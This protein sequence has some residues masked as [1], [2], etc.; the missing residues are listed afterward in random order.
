MRS[1]QEDLITTTLFASQHLTL[2]GIGGLHSLP[3]AC[4]EV[5]SCKH[6]AQRISQASHATLHLRLHYKTIYPSLQ[7]PY[8]ALIPGSRAGNLRPLIALICG[9]CSVLHISAHLPLTS[10]LL[11]S[12]QRSQAVSKCALGP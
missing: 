12:F 7:T 9:F 11:S 1:I 4:M 10:G 5:L 6:T 3:A 8:T 2:G